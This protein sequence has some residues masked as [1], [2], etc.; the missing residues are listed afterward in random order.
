MSMWDSSNP[1]TQGCKN[2]PKPLNSKNNLHDVHI[3]PT[4]WPST[5]SNLTL[6]VCEHI[7]PKQTLF[8]IVLAHKK[9]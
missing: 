5:F 2:T 9:I 1:Q 8:S 6:C 4:Q 3:G 7:L